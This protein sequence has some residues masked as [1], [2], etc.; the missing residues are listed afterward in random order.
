V[1]VAGSAARSRAC[2]LLL[3]ISVA[4]CGYAG[5]TGE[6]YEHSLAAKSVWSALQQ[7]QWNL[8]QA[9]KRPFVY[10]ADPAADVDTIA[11]AAKV[12]AGYVAFTAKASDRRVLSIP[13]DQA[14]QLDA[15]LLGELQ[16]R[17]LISRSVAYELK[18]RST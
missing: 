18:R 8:R 5:E 15:K 2:L 4:A 16:S 1:I 13:Q 10:N 17:G 14:I 7:A 6:E 12:G 9:Q 11:F 3:T